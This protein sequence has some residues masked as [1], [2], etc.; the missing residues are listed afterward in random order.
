[1][2]RKCNKRKMKELIGYFSKKKYVIYKNNLYT[3]FTN[4]QKKI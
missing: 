2:E 3:N 1:M 4:R